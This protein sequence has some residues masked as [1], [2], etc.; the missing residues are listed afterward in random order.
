[1]IEENRTL[2]PRIQAAAI[3]EAFPSYSVAVSVRQGDHPRFEAVTRNDDNPWCLISAHAD[4]IWHELEG[5]SM[6]ELSLLTTE[7]LG[8]ATV[9]RRLVG[10]ALRRYREHAGYG[11]ED[12]ANVLECDR[13]KISRIETGQRGIRARELRDLLDEYGIGES[14]QLTLTAIADPRS[15]RHGWWQDYADIVPAAHQDLMI[16]ETLASEIF[17][18]DPQQVP[19]L[20]QTQDYAR[21]VAESDPDMPEPGTLDRLTEMSITRQQVIMNERCTA[22]TAVIGEAALRQQ[23]GNARVMRDQARWLAEV[24]GTCPWVTLQ[25]LP[26][27]A[28]AH[29]KR[30]GPM[31]ILRFAQAPSLGVVHLRGLNGGVCLI[32]RAAVA[33]H[34]RAFTHLQVSALPPHQSAQL[35]REMAR[36]RM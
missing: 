28:G 6:P 30:T 12:A 1:M 22:V 35:I 21:A 20:L 34:V 19:D 7:E 5:T 9:R 15:A 26:F 16:M 2:L 11:L 13:S 32:D 29:P 8:G 31:S 18:Y 4:E 3:Q 24:A 17:I 10:A 23:A 36:V 14:E 33:G 25:V 27:R